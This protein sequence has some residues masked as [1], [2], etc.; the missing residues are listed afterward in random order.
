MKKMMFVMLGLGIVLGCLSCG[1][2]TPGSFSCQDVAPATDSS[3][4]LTYATKHNIHPVKDS[5]YLFY[6]II[7]KGTGATPLSNSKIYIRYQGQLMDGTYFDS[8]LTSIRL[9]LDSLIRGWQIGIP[10]I[11][12]GGQI[13]LLIPSAFGFGCRGTNSI[14]AN[15][16]L[17]F[18]VYLDS[19][20]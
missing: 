4:L 17:Y 9:P 18:N 13:K 14:P 11:Q 5:T 19:L 12:V 10:K 1:K 8:T 3:S 16:P 6:E 15:A 20:K 2:T 7:Q